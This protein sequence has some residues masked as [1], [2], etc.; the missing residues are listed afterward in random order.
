MEERRVRNLT[1]RF[2]RQAGRQRQGQ[3]MSFG[4]QTLQ[5]KDLPSAPRKGAILLKIGLT[6]NERIL[7]ARK[8]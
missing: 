1:A 4:L 5:S 2:A 7:S 6:L 3:T 8:P